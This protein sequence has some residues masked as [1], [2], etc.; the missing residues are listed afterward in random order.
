VEEYLK[1]CRFHYRTLTV[2]CMTALLFAFTPSDRQWLQEAIQEAEIVSKMD[3]GAL[4]DK[5]VRADPVTGTYM[6]RIEEAIS[7]VV[8]GYSE[9]VHS[10][11]LGRQFRLP[12]RSP[13]IEQLQSYIE[14]KHS[15]V[16]TVPQLDDATLAEIAEH[17]RNSQPTGKIDRLAVYPRDE[18]TQVK[19][20][21]Q[22]GS[23]EFY[24]DYPWKGALHREIHI[25]LRQLI[26]EHPQYERLLLRSDDNEK[27]TFPSLHRFWGE[28][29][30]KDP[31][32]A[33]EYL[34][35]RKAH[36][37]DDIALLGLSIPA[38]LAGIAVP[39][40]IVLLALYLHICLRKLERLVACD[41]ETGAAQLDFPWL[42]LFHDRLSRMLAFVSCP[43]LPV[44][45]TVLVVR[46]SFHLG[47]VLTAVVAIVSIGVAFAESRWWPRLAKRLRALSEAGVP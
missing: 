8:S 20:H 9:P 30:D 1:T 24:S 37:R 45:A 21:W 47:S 25:D 12:E 23:T 43:M 10:V 28:I 40:T 13:R 7:P 36:T 4:F 17:L 35:L 33:V 2:V 14:I 27:V 18:K 46:R 31:R 15:A 5:A 6:K 38:S 42:P 44:F 22:G 41:T 16:F 29:R 32:D 3:F 11:F 26:L 34:E 39:I 19:L